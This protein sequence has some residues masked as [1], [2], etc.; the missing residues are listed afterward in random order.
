M[1]K[2]IIGL[3]PGTT[4]PQSLVISTPR[5][6]LSGRWAVVR[7]AIFHGLSA[8]FDDVLRGIEVGLANFQVDNIFALTLQGASLI[9]NFKGGLGAEPRHAL[10]QSKFV[11][12][13]FFHRRK[14]CHYIPPGLSAY[15]CA[16][17]GRVF[18]RN[19]MPRW[20]CV[21]YLAA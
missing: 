1:V 8:G 18:A 14:S 16:Q 6:W 3:P 4:T 21:D 10:G 19:S 17:P 9:Q 2:K 13:S 11:L 15:D 7:P 5:L 20:S 12:R